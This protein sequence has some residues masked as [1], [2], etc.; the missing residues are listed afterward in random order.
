MARSKR[1]VVGDRCQCSKCREWFPVTSFQKIRAGKPD[2]YYLTACNNCRKLQQYA[3]MNAD[4]K[5][6]IR[7]KWT[8]TVTRARKLGVSMEIT[9]E[10]FWLQFDSQQGMCFY[11]DQELVT[12]IGEGRSPNA[13][14]VDKI[15]PSVGYVKGNVVFTTNQVNTIKSNMSLEQMELWTPEWYRRATQFLT[16]EST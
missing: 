3:T 8:R 6:Y 1:V 5:R 9:H 4:P 10:E 7:D 13:A 15:I 16:K 2:E 11:S 14:S 12:R